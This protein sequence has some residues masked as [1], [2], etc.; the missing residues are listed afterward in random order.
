M[1][2]CACISM[3][4]CGSACVSTFKLIKKIDRKIKNREVVNIKV[5]K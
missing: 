5:N 3:H 1:C 4:A 2:A